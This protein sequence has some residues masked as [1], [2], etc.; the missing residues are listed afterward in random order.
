MSGHTTLLSGGRKETGHVGGSKASLSGRLGWGRN[1]GGPE[2]SWAGSAR[3]DSEGL[4][5]QD[6]D[7]A[8]IF[9]PGDW[10]KAGESAQVKRGRRLQAGPGWPERGGGEA[11]LAEAVEERRNAPR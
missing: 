3:L 2:A 10:G 7:L 4:C 6:R 1:G 9:R 11:G 5:T 8:F